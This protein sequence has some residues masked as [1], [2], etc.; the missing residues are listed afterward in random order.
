M[1]LSNKN[2]CTI[3]TI[4]LMYAMNYFLEIFCAEN[5]E[6]SDTVEYS[7]Q[8]RKSLQQKLCTYGL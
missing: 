7:V 1:D 8:R 2:K 3:L 5:Y 6:C 4:T